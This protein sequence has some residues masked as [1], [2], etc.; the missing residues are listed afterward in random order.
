MRQVIMDIERG[1][2]TRP[3]GPGATTATPPDRLEAFEQ[4]VASAWH[5][6]EA[7]VIDFL[8]SVRANVRRG[9][10][11]VATGANAVRGAVHDATDASG[12]ALNF[13]AH[14]RSHPWLAVGGALL[15]GVVVGRLGSRRGCP[16]ARENQSRE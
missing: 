13:P 1:P 11:A 7:S 12:W 15:L 6:A 3:G 5:R 14:V 16:A 9:S 10:A 8:A 4:G 2:G